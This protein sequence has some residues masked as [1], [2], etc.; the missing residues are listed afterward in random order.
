MILSAEVFHPIQMAGNSK[1]SF[2][3]LGK[4]VMYYS[5]DTTEEDH[6]VINS[7]LMAVWA[8]FFMIGYLNKNKF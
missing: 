4:H 7:L 1:N 5:T 2:S 6:E 8:I 3:E